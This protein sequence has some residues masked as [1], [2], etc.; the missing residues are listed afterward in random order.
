MD[1]A[2]GAPMRP[3]G[4]VQARIDVTYAVKLPTLRALTPPGIAYLRRSAGPAAGVMDA[5]GDPVRR[6]LHDLRDDF[7][8]VNQES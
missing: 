6:I 8:T 2:L 4:L 1:C 5:H 7:Q 3:A